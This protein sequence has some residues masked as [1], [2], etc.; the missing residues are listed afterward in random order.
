MDAGLAE[1][2]PARR[3]FAL[4]RDGKIQSGALAS[5]ES[6][7]RSRGN[8]DDHEWMAVDRNLSIDDAGIAAKMF[9]PVRE[10]EDRHGIAARHAI[11]FGRKESSHAGAN[12]ED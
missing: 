12:A 9:C 8:A 4:H 5:Q 2:I 1:S 7:E 3:N 6:V 10:A 11:L